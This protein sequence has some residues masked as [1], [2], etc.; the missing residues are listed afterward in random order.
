MSALLRR[1]RMTS[2]LLR[3]RIAAGMLFVIAEIEVAVVGGDAPVV[4]LMLAAAGYSLPFAWR[5]VWPLPVVVVVVRSSATVVTGS[6]A[7][8]RAESASRRR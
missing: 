7:C 3:D 8:N 5:R 1:F 2:P 6:A 4:L